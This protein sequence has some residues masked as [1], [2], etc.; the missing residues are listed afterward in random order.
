MKNKLYSINEANFKAC[1][2]ALDAH[3]DRL[4]LYEDM[5]YENPSERN[6]T[7]Y[8]LQVGYLRGLKDMLGFVLKGN[9]LSLNRDTDGKYYICET[10][11]SLAKNTTA[12]ME[13]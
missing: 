3:Q 10:D 5:Y 1:V 8:D 4:K 13:G 9:G 6:G 2:Y 7:F 11:E 12:S